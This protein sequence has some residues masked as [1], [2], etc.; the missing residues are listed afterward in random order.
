VTI[1]EAARLQNEG[2]LSSE[3]LTRN[4]LDAIAK[5]NDRLN[6]FITVTGDEAIAQA[7]RLDQERKQG[8]VRG[9][10]HGIPIAL[11][12]VFATKGIRTTCGSKIF[13]NHVPMRDS[14]AAEKLEAAGTVLLGK[15]GMHELAYGV[16]SN[17]PHFG[18]VRNPHNEECIPGG[19]SGGSGSAV[20]AH[21][22]LMAMGSDTGGS[23]RIPAGYCGTVGIKPTTGR[24]SRYG[25]MPLDFTLDHMGPLT[26]SVADAALCLEALAGHDPRD[27]S[28][29]RV[30]PTGYLP[31]PGASIRGLRIGLP[32]NF[33]FD[34][35][36]PEIEASVHGVARHA[37]S[38]GAV[39]TPVRVP[40]IAAINTTGRVILLV[41]ASATLEPYLQ[42]RSLFGADVLALFD[43]GRL[44]PGTDYVQAQRLRRVFQREFA[45]LWKQV[46]CVMTPTMPVTAPR[47]G[48]ATITLG[49]VE[50]DVR[51]A[52]TRFVRA[53][54]VLGLPALA[55]PSGTSTGGLPMSVQFIGRPF[56]EA[57]LFR[58]GQAC[59]P[60]WA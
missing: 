46:D 28:S 57:T 5:R 10:L 9:P 27:D 50:E 53:I 48:A 44:I 26:N 45:E 55:V 59:C 31:A 30:P 18:P 60:D 36:D 35:V 37:E 23:I 16:T 17:N 32:E 7:R 8:K 47:I 40:D 33:Y 42:D 3:E 56:D 15:T 38:L 11:K 20:G 2:R 22:A 29:S 13:A 19:S 54:N 1:T 49:G 41:E 43:Q 34:S 14:A 12:D 4:C 21:M 6:A 51:L 58:L 25:V 39:V 24:V 52:S